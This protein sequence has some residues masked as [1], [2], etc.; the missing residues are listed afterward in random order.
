MAEGLRGVKCSGGSVNGAQRAAEAG[1]G[2]G[3]MRCAW[4]RRGSAGGRRGMQVEAEEVR[5]WRQGLRKQ[6]LVKGVCWRLRLRMGCRS[7][8]GSGVQGGGGGPQVTRRLVEGFV[9]GDRG[10]VG[11][12]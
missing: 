10:F 3:V 7:G 8:S 5:S 1:S 12:A 4:Q 2:G 9:G 6:R 11:D